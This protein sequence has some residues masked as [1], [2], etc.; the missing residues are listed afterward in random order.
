[1]TDSTDDDRDDYI[2]NVI[3]HRC[4]ELTDDDLAMLSQ[5]DEFLGELLPVEI[6]H[7]ILEVVDRLFDRMTAL[8]DAVAQARDPAGNDDPLASCRRALADM[9]VEDKVMVA[10]Q[11]R[12][13]VEAERGTHERQH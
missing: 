11:L 9:T 4:P 10:D 6:G 5:P 7:Q 13:W 3:A 1:M 8:E 2:R 12:G